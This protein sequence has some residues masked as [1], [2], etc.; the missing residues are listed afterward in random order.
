MRIRKKGQKYEKK[1]RVLTVESCVYEPKKQN[2]IGEN[3]VR[4]IKQHLKDVRK[5]SR[6]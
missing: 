1:L 6:I 4:I 5:K 3:K 2:F